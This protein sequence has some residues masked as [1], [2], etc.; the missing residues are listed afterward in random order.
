MGV[1]GDGEEAEGERVSAGEAGCSMRK[2]DV[3][4]SFTLAAVVARSSAV[5]T[6]KSGGSCCSVVCAAVVGGVG[7]SFG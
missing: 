4:R 7:L 6:L 5:M 2:V 1:V 3:G